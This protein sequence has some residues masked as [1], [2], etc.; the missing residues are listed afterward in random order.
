MTL[1]LLPYMPSMPKVCSTFHDTSAKMFVQNAR[2][3]IHAFLTCLSSVYCACLCSMPTLYACLVCLPCMPAL[4]S[5]S[6]CLHCPTCQPLNVFILSRVSS[7]V[8]SFRCKLC[9]TVPYHI[10][11]YQQG[12]I[13]CTV[14]SVLHSGDYSTTA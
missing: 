2:P 10:A 9:L 14:C 7:V 6:A 12:R 1:I 4:Y 5:C 13:Q 8:I 11:L 3:C